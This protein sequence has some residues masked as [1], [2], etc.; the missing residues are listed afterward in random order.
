MNIPRPI[1]AASMH[2]YAPKVA[3]VIKT[4][5]GEGGQTFLYLNPQ[6]LIEFLKKKDFNIHA[7]LNSLE[8]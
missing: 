2:N 3:Q 4:Q 7:K 1:Y 5:Q 6:Q 8:N